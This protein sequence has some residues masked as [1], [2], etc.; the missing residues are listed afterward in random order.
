MRRN[1]RSMRR[2]KNLAFLIVLVFLLPLTVQ[3]QTASESGNTGLWRVLT[4]ATLGPRKTSF[5]VWY[6]R[7]NRNPGDL[8]I[9]TSG[10]SAAYG[11]GDRFELGVA[12]EANKRV[13]VRRQDE[14]SFGQQALGF[15]GNQTPG[16]PPLPNE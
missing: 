15:F 5:S 12:L 16:S 13:L 4:A 8:T 14:L 6:D 9:S 1:T 7:T 11:I 3:A 2:A 10:V